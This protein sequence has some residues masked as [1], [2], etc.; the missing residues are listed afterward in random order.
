MDLSKERKVISQAVKEAGDLLL[1][2]FKTFDRGEIKMKSAHEIVTDSDLLSEKIILAALKQHFPQHGILS[3][4]KGNNEIQ[5]D[6]LWVIDPLD[7]TTNFSMHNPLWSVAVAL[8]YQKQIVLSLIYA[9]ALQELYLA[10][11][12]QGASLNGQTIKVSTIK[13]GKVL[14]VFCHGYD[15]ASLKTAL[16]YFSWQKLNGFDCRQLGS[17]SIELAWLAAGRL[18]SLVIPGANVWDV[19]AGVLL[20]REAGGRVTDFANQDWQFNSLDIIASNS[21]VHQ[22]V[23][24]AIKNSLHD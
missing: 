8:F 2:K 4:E 3:E 13:E 5:S 12:D 10:E 7:G 18:E 11:Q 1:A 16:N 6:W 15:Q 17:A 19:A 23:C 24:Q 9:P 14:N 21:L 22:Q 20:V